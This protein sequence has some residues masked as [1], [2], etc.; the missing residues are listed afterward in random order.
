VLIAYDPACA[1]YSP[2]NLLMWLVFQKCHE[3]GLS[4]YDLG[5]GSDKYKYCWKPVELPLATFVDRGPVGMTMK[6]IGH[7]RD[8]YA[9]AKDPYEAARR[10]PRGAN[11][12][13]D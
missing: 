13:C 10:M 12:T 8:R 9:Q 1:E 11:A 2:G 3:L 4:A 5:W 7:A 6:A